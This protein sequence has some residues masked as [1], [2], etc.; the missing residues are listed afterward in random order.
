MPRC[1]VVLGAQ[2]HIVI[3]EE[4]EEITHLSSSPKEDPVS[5]TAVGNKSSSVT[6]SSSELDLSS[7]EPQKW[8]IQKETILNCTP[9]I[10]PDPVS[11]ASSS[12]DSSFLPSLPSSP[13][14]S[15]VEFSQPSKFIPSPPVGSCIN[16]DLLHEDLSSTSKKRKEPD[17][18]EDRHENIR[19]KARDNTLI[20]ANKMANY[21]PCGR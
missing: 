10:S 16:K 15:E 5:V 14:P 13:S 18:P 12:S 6:S 4:I 21:Y 1:Q 20:S 8:V 11:S 2:Q 19:K 7:V 17:S 9:S 3:E